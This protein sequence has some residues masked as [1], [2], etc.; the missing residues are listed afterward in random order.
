MMGETIQASCDMLY[1]ASCALRSRPAD[2][3]RVSEMDLP[4]V[5][6]AAK[7]NGMEA[8]ADLG[9]GALAPKAPWVSQWRE[10]RDRALRKS[11]LFDV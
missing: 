2:P 8:V 1:L 3:K 10:C 9:L 6:K 7:D 11:I 5:Y 4:A